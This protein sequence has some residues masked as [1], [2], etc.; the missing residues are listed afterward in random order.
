MP[1]I[2]VN[3]PCLLTS[4]SSSQRRKDGGWLTQLDVL[5][6]VRDTDGYKHLQNTDVEL[7]DV[8]LGSED[9]GQVSRADRA[10]GKGHVHVLVVVPRSTGEDV[11]WTAKD[12]C[13]VD[14]DVQ[15]NLWKSVVRVSSEDVCSGTALV[16]DQTPTLVSYDELAA[17]DRHHIH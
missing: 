11:A 16:V 5:Q 15:L 10:A 13:T 2:S 1:F 3:P 7:Q 9:L 12:L 17:V 4:C 8:G 6:G 14:P